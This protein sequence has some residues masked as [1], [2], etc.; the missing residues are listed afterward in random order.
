MITTIMGIEM[1]KGSYKRDTVNCAQYCNA[2]PTQ[3]FL[4]QNKKVRSTLIELGRGG[5]EGERGRYDGEGG[6][7]IV[8]T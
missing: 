2:Y 5:R 6:A 4:V 3:E 8:M 1:L 7:T